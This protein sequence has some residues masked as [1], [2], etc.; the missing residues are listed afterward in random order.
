MRRLRKS[1]RRRI[2][3]AVLFVA[4][5]IILFF[6]G[7]M[8]FRYTVCQR[9]ESLLN[10]KDAV[11]T[12][13][14]RMVYVTTKDVK[15]GECFTRENA[16]E[17]Y[18]LSEQNPESLAKEVFG[19]V[20]CAD[21]PAGVILNTALCCS[22]ELSATER[23]CVFDDI[24]QTERFEDY[25]TVDVRLRYPNGENYCVLKQKRLR[26]T[27]GNTEECRFILTEREQLMMSGARYDVQLYG[28]A[29]LYLVGFT[30]ERLQENA[31]SGYIPP[32]QI[33]LQIQELDN[34]KERDP[35]GWY[36]QRR[37]LEER[38]SEHVKQRREGLL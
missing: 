6:A 8:T 19:S 27:E 9:Y 36:E 15:A 29:E 34:E 12:A 4:A 25:A 20:S 16:E 21:I 5:Q 10:E 17:R 28:G 2:L 3:Y 22:Q 33:M 30:E 11:L 13:A 18:L 24:G 35:A 32:V 38:L 23:E 26:R 7:Q 37:A 1:V 31:E 14:G